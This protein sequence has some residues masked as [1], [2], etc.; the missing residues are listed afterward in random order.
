[1]IISGNPWSRSLITTFISFFFEWDYRARLIE[2]SEAGSREAF[3]THLFR[4]CL[5]FESLLKENTRKPSCKPTLG[6]IIR[7]LAADLGIPRKAASISCNSLEMVLQSLTSN[8]PIDDA[9]QC[10]GKTRNTLGHNL[11]W[12]ATSLDA[13]KYNLL[14]ENIAVSCLHAISCLYR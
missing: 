10:T 1:M 6:P 4:G 13:N 14:A 3:F 12:I 11:V 7:D 2:I 9:I 5:L 8:Q